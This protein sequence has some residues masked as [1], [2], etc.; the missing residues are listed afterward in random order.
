MLKK[1]EIIEKEGI[2]INS[3]TVIEGFPDVG[4]VGVIASSYLVDKLK[5]KEVAHIESTLFPPVMVLHKGILSEP[6]SIFG[7]DNII[8]VTSEIAIPPKLIYDLSLELSQWFEK[9]KAKILISLS[10]IPVQNRQDIEEPVVYG[11]GNN[12]KSIEILKENKINIIEEGFISGVYPL[13]LKECLKRNIS[14]L[15]LLAQSFL[16][17]PDPGASA[18]TILALNKIININVDVKPLLDKANEV[19]VKARDLMKQAQNTMGPMGKSLEGEIPM[20]YR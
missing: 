20:M 18:S 17:Y 3:P 7:N 13:L 9:K 2:S 11:V 8:V 1:I 15:A 10:G 16:K 14:A 5:L 19:K 6:V 4:L 12:S